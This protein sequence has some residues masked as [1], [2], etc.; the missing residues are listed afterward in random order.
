M[1]RTKLFGGLFIFA[2]LL[3]ACGNA[4]LTAST[5]M[6]PEAFA[7]AVVSESPDQAG[8]TIQATSPATTAIAWVTPQVQAAGVTFHTYASSAARSKVSYHLYTPPAYTQFRAQRFPV[9]YWLHGSDSP[10]Q[11]IPQLAGT[12]DAA[13]RAGKI[14]PMLIVFPNGLDHGQYVNSKDGKQP[15]ETMIIRELLPLVDR[16]FRTIADRKGRIVEGFSMGGYGA[17]RL[18][19]KYPELFGTVSMDA[20]GTLD[21]DFSGPRATENPEERNEILRTVYGN[22]MAYYRAC[23]PLTITTANVRALRGTQ[24]IRQVIGDLDFTLSDNVAFHGHLDRLGIRHEFKTV[25]GVK[26]ECAKL[27]A[28]LGEGNWSFYRDAL[29]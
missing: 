28:G 29:R 16:S 11:G 7:P 23:S 14:P 10:Y 18:G 22:D 12:F 17:G 27:I 9:L 1:H 4:P 26:H 8:F 6:N 25:A 21:L 3:S 2:S 19:F 15:I 24:R 5:S 13:I 20:A